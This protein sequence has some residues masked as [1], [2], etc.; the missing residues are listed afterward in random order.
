MSIC[1]VCKSEKPC[2]CH[3]ERTEELFA[4]TKIRNQLKKLTDPMDCEELI[5][6]RNFASQM[7]RKE[8]P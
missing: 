6:V 4:E 5:R 1:M 2:N 7:P 8:K 3:A